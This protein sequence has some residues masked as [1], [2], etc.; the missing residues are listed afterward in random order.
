MEAVFAR[1]RRSSRRVVLPLSLLLVQLAGGSSRLMAQSGSAVTV[2][3][4]TSAMTVPWYPKPLAYHL[5]PALA[6]IHNVPPTM[7]PTAAART[8][9]CVYGVN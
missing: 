9:T 5:N 1:H 4:G 6:P 8:C 7:A 3:V 2:A